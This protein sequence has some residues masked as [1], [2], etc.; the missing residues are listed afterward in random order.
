MRLE[1]IEY[2]VE[3]AR[4]N[5]ISK[6]AQ[7]LFI[8]QPTLS[9]AISAVEHELNGE[10]FHRSNKGIRLT[11]F[12]E[13]ILP[14]LL[15][16][17]QHSKQIKEL[18]YCTDKLMKQ[19]LHLTAYPAGSFAIIPGLVQKIK[20]DYP[21][22]NI[23]VYE[24]QTEN[25]VKRLVAS[26]YNIGL[27]ALSSVKY[28]PFVLEAQNYGFV[29]KALYEDKMMAYLPQDH[30]LLNET[31]TIEKLRSSQVAL[32]HTFTLPNENVFYTDFHLFD[33]ACTFG[34]Y[35]TLK[36]V[37]VRQKFLTIAPQLVFYNDSYI[38]DGTLV[39]KKIEDFS[40]NLTN[41]IIFPADERKISIL[42][43]AA[44]KIIEDFFADIRDRSL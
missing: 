4:C 39:E 30:A 29:C 13:K 44:L 37:M 42:E 16:I 32:L 19:H 17:L 23:H 2:I 40:E 38:L 6:A 12:G 26:G 11:E 21:N 36:R 34:S 14:E 15:E 35:D 27:G 31:L 43:R 10:I 5:S 24:V 8:G 41:F 25:I 20:E 7:N 1:H 3:A 28:R 18:S 22:A 33:S 9:M